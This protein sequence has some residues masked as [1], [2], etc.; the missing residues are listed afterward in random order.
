MVPYSLQAIQLDFYSSFIRLFSKMTSLQLF[1]SPQTSTKSSPPSLSDD[2]PAFFSTEKTEVIEKERLVCVLYSPPSLLWLWLNSWPP[3]WG[4]A[5]HLCGRSHPSC[6]LK[7]TTSAIVSSPLHL[8]FPSLCL[9]HP[10]TKML[11]LRI[12]P[13][14]DLTFPPRYQNTSLPSSTENVY[15]TFD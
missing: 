6:Q 13:S 10:H 15:K 8:Q 5:L 7:N 14:L 9:S 1:L 11:D 12:K 4:Q 3:S 2:E